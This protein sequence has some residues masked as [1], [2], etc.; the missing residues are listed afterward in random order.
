[1]PPQPGVVEIE[2]GDFE[3]RRRALR[4]RFALFEQLLA[5]FAVLH[6]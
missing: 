4:D 5:V 1:M 6:A 3:F 2:A